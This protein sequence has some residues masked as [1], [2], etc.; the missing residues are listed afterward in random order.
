[1]IYTLA[2][3]CFTALRPGG[4]NDFFMIICTLIFTGYATLPM[5]AANAAAAGLLL[6]K[7]NNKTK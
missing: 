2:L 4:F 6:M 3:T 7:A 5:P 1:M